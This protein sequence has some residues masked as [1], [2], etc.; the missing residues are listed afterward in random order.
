MSDRS[1]GTGWWL[2]SDGKWYPP[3][4]NPS[5]AATQ[6]IMPADSPFDI[7]KAVVTMKYAQFDGRAR[8]AE[9][10]WFSLVNAGFIFGLAIVV[11]IFGAFSDTIGGLG[12][13]VYL[14]YI[15]GMILPSR[16]VAVRRLHDTDKSGA[17]FLLFLLPIIGSIILLVF[18]LIDGD[19]T[20]NRYGPSPKYT[21]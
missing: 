14:A 13:L 15:I 4:S 3:E 19:R 1:E 2:A 11:G 16:S 17:L 6:M 20:A 12:V 21:A 9:F 8:R 7:W 10:W 5:V 18:Y